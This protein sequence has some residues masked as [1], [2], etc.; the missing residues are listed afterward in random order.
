M[1]WGALSD[2]LVFGQIDYPAEAL[3]SVAERLGFTSVYAVG[4]LPEALMDPLARAAQV[5]DVPH[6]WR[7]KEAEAEEQVDEAT[8][9]RAKQILLEDKS[10]RGAE[11]VCY[12]GSMS[13]D[14]KVV[15]LALPEQ[16]TQWQFLA[17][18]AIR[19]KLNSK[20]HNPEV[21]V[22]SRAIVA[23]KYRGIG[24]GSVLV[25][26]RLSML[27]NGYFGSI[28]KAIHF[29]T[30]SEKILK[31]MSRIEKEHG[32]HFVHI[33]DEQLTT[34]DGVHTVHDYLCFL[35][36]YQAEIISSLEAMGVV[37]DSGELNDAL[38]LFSTYLQNFMQH[39]VRVVSGAKLVAAFEVVKSLCG[40]LASFKKISQYFEEILLFRREIGAEDPS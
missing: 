9:I 4:G 26:H 6:T 11:I 18:G 29:G 32:I 3:L 14:L 22:I 30:E 10:L 35:P 16:R 37:L 15:D 5:C 23:P 7:V 24:L 38:V 34:D 27:L 1:T 31:A 39:G 12:I 17:A 21:P 20:Y 8:A 19:N 25:E 13:C 36:W 33:G 2:S 40:E 28:P